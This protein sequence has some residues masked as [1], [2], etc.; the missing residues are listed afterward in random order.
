[1]DQIMKYYLVF[2]GVVVIGWVVLYF[3]FT[4]SWVYRTE[5][6]FTTG[7]AD[8]DIFFLLL[9]AITWLYIGLY[10]CWWYLHVL[11]LASC[12][13]NDYVVQQTRTISS[14]KGLPTELREIIFKKYLEGLHIFTCAYQLKDIE[15]LTS[16]LAHGDFLKTEPKLYSDFMGVA[17]K[18]IQYRI[19]MDS[20]RIFEDTSVPCE[21]FRLIRN[22]QVDIRHPN[23]MPPNQCYQYTETGMTN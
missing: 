13:K 1:M 16:K 21:N 2:S 22:L 10:L 4:I 15:S 3:A 20:F 5:S 7:S 8:W 17:L 18:S 19:F 14:L 11:D 12:A 6:Y 9:S 23:I